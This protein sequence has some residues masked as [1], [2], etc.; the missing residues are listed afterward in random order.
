M[1]EAWRGKF[2]G[3][4]AQDTCLD[5]DPAKPTCLNYLKQLGVSHVQIMPMFD[6][7]STDEANPDAYN[8]G[9]DPVN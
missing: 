1:P 6:F 2:L 4:T 3:F 5:G 7:G 9:Y 8:W